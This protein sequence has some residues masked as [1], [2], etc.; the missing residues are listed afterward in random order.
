MSVGIKEIHE[1]FYCLTVRGAFVILGYT[2]ID[3]RTTVDLFI[4]KY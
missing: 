3:Y 1:I 2:K 4:L